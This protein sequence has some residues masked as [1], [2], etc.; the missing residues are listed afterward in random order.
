MEKRI[1]PFLVLVLL[2][3]YLVPVVQ[4]SMEIDKTTVVSRVIDGDTFDTTSGHR[5]RLADIDT[6]EKGE[7]GY[8]NAKNFLIGLVYNKRV[9]LDIDDIYRT[10]KYGRLVCVVYVSYNST[11]FK[12]VNKALLIRGYAVIWNFHNEFNPNTWSLYSPKEESLGF[13]KSDSQ[14]VE[15]VLSTSELYMVAIVIVVIAGT[16]MFVLYR[17]GK[18]SGKPSSASLR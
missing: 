1:F 12:N 16:I 9:Y 18:A 15:P 4:G 8:D 3:Q 14:Q 11:H 13:P 6:P 10:D 7:S 2:M 5:I 17:K